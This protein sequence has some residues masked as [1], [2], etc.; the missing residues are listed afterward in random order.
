MRQD[1]CSQ[2]RLIRVEQPR[3][4]AHLAVQRLPRLEP[5]EHVRMR[6]KTLEQPRAGVAECPDPFA[7]RREQINGRAAQVVL[8]R[9]EAQRALTPQDG[10][11]L[12]AAP[13]D[14]RTRWPIPADGRPRAVG[15]PH[16]GRAIRGRTHSRLHAC[17]GLLCCVR[18]SATR[19]GVPRRGARGGCRL[20][21]AHVCERL[22][23]QH[24]CDVRWV[25]CCGGER[26][27][28][29][30]LEGR[31]G[32]RRTGR[33]V[34]A[35]EAK[36]AASHGVAVPAALET[37]QRRSPTGGAL[38]AA[39][40]RS[41]STHCPKC[42]GTRFIAAGRLLEPARAS[43]S[44]EEISGSSSASAP[45]AVANS[46]RHAIWHPQVAPAGPRA[47]MPAASLRKKAHASSVESR[48]RP[49]PACIAS[50]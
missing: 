15:R 27:H 24:Q 18:L 40:V 47:A 23:E 8:R 38:W 10:R 13:G 4:L 1:K 17:P 16:P 7:R 5:A 30:R 45:S 6:H 2:Q 37:V 46:P 29:V 50:M 31:L 34:R 14:R 39:A 43:A 33:D 22:V 28:A 12:V 25:Q 44:T 35:A 21:G 36:E 20:R 41:A 48:P 49:H 26:Q 32:R 11:K 19:R 9:A 42:R 3:T